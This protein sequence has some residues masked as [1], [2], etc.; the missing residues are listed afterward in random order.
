MFMPPML[1]SAAIAAVIVLEGMVVVVVRTWVV[2]RFLPHH[3]RLHVVAS[4]VVAV[5]G[6]DWPETLPAAS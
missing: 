3:V 4:D 1:G 5:S 2:Q 6:A